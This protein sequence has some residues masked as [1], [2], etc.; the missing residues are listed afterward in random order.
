MLTLRLRVVSRTWFLLLLLLLLLLIVTPLFSRIL[1]ILF[2][3]SPE[4]QPTLHNPRKILT[5]SWP[6]LDFDAMSW[7]EVFSA[8]FCCFVFFE[9]DWFSCVCVISGQAFFVC[10]FG[11]G[12]TV[13]SIITFC[14]YFL[15]HSHFFYIILILL[16]ICCWRPFFTSAVFH[17]FC[18]QKCHRWT[19]VIIINCIVFLYRLS[20][21]YLR[22]QFQRRTHTHKK[23]PTTKRKMS[24]PVQNVFLFVLRKKK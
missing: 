11:I 14:V 13:P 5:K 12:C 22:L 16:R 24:D 10:F 21:L 9:S 17:T 15:P 6:F 4:T 23:K 2:F 8:R 19:F 20:Q 18:N 3:P 7:K 1:I